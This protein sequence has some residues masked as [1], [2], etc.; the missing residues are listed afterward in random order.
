MP[1]NF[2]SPE[3]LSHQRTRKN[4]VSRASPAHMNSL[5]VFLYLSSTLNFINYRFKHV[6]IFTKVGKKVKINFLTFCS[7]DSEVLCVLLPSPQALNKLK[8]FMR[9]YTRIQL[10]P[11]ALPPPPITAELYNFLYSLINNFNPYL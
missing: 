11:S 5:L 6:A 8:I 7:F 2:S 9:A 10:L 3:Y 1:F 4:R